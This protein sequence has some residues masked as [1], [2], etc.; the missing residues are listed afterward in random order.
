LPDDDPQS[1]FTAFVRIPRS[2]SVELIGPG[3]HHPDALRSKF[4]TRV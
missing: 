1:A 4:S 2:Q 3:P